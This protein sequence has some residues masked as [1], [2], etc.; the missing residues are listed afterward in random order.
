MATQLM[1]FDDTFG[2]TATYALGLL[3]YNLKGVGATKLD[4]VFHKTPKLATY[5]TQSCQDVARIMQQE[6]Q[7]ETIDFIDGKLNEF[8]NWIL[9]TYLIRKASANVTKSKLF[10]LLME[11]EKQIGIDMIPVLQDERYAA[12]A[13]S[14][15]MIG[16]SIHLTIL[17]E[18]ALIDPMAAQPGFPPYVRSIKKYAEIYSNHV[19]DTYT[20]IIN[21]RTSDSVIT[22]VT[23]R[24]DD[25]A[26][27]LAVSPCYQS[28][29]S[30]WRDAYNGH[31]GRC[32]TDRMCQWLSWSAG[33]PE[34]LQENVKRGREEYI[35][36]VKRTLTKQLN[37]PPF[38]C[39]SWRKLIDRPLPI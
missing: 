3:D 30:F 24:V 4:S 16:A 20:S 37:N 9:G 26:Q 33:T 6:I 18:L 7:K 2:I 17:Q 15:F 5:F 28:Y 19:G 14:T 11:K 12:S 34:D 27:A 36:Q 35:Q 10:S 29:T 22:P 23:T 32:S 38:I 31:E 21:A 39:E 13:L 8:Q 25:K 1:E